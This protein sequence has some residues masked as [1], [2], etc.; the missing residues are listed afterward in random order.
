MNNVNNSSIGGGSPLPDQDWLQS[1]WEKVRE[2]A[3]RMEMNP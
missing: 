1:S 2:D 3:E